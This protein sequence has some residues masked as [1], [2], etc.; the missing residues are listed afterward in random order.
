MMNAELEIP[1]NE[2][3]LPTCPVPDAVSCITCDDDRACPSLESERLGL[4]TK[5]HSR[6]DED[7]KLEAWIASNLDID[8]DVAS[9]PRS[10]WNRMIEGLPGLR[11]APRAARATKGVE[12]RYTGWSRF[13]LA[14]KRGITLVRLRDAALLKE[15][16]IQELACDLIDLIEAGNWRVVLD[17]ARVERLAS[18]VVSAVKGAAIRCR[19]GDGGAL[20]ICG[21]SADQA[22]IF[23]IAGIGTAVA[24]HADEAAAIDSPWPEASGP[25]ALPVDVLRA[26]L[27]AAG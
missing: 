9:S 10:I 7:L 17:F 1:P 5:P 4:L 24:F 16:L 15:S 14:Y 26:L 3:R 21:L 6:A 23:P 18:L 8:A 11:R 19:A 2:S 13:D 27:S 22:A 25:R 20:K 12:S